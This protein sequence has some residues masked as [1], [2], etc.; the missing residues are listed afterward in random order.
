[1]QGQQPY[2]SCRVGVHNALNRNFDNALLPISAPI[3]GRSNML[4]FIHQ[5]YNLG[6]GMLHISAV[7]HTYAA[8]SSIVVVVFCLLGRE[9]LACM[10]YHII[11]ESAESPVPSPQK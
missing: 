11:S 8:F 2:H 4:S 9:S 10:E 3:L 5:P 7:W 1:M 6:D